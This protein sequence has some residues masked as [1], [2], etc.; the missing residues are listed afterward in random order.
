MPKKSAKAK[1]SAKTKS[2]KQAHKPLP[3]DH[4]TDWLPAEITEITSE[5][6]SEERRGRKKKFTPK[7]TLALQL[8][9]L[10]YKNS[11][12]AAPQK[13]AAA[14]VQKLAEDKFH[15]PK[16]NFLDTIIEQIIKPVDEAC[17]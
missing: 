11:H 17:E 8:A 3:L 16:I 14:H 5:G 9:Y 13:D 1:K 10:N 6:E 4:P 2:K 7:Q 15:F 12:P